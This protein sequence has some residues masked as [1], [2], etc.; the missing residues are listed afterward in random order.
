VCARG[1]NRALVRGPSTSPLVAMAQLISLLGGIAFLVAVNFY[2]QYVFRRF[3]VFSGWPP[4]FIGPAPR[5][6]R[7]VLFWLVMAFS[8]VVLVPAAII[9]IAYPL[10]M[11]DCGDRYLPSEPPQCS[12][13]ARLSF[14]LGG[15]VIGLPLM[16]MWM[17]FLLARITDNSSHGA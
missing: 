16:A 10:G 9:A 1:S 14:A 11:L 8:V 17:R 3:G 5:G 4:E 13:G 7:L 12:P 2:A 6:K 15:I